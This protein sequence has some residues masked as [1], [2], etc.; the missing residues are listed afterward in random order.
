MGR[1]QHILIVEIRVNYLGEGSR[2]TME[3]AEKVSKN[4]TGKSLGGMPVM[5]NFFTR[6]RSGL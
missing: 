2:E 5:P 3:G 1:L 4:L 6:I